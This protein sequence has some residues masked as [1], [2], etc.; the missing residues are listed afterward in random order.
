MYITPNNMFSLSPIKR[1]KFIAYYIPSL[2]GMGIINMIARTTD[3]MEVV[4]TI[5]FIMLSIFMIITVIRRL[6]DLNETKIEMFLFFVLSSI[7][8]LNIVMLLKLCIKK[9]K[10]KNNDDDNLL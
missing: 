9:S 10:I 3:N 6:R 8:I 4:T 2:F 7:P 1:K 5:L